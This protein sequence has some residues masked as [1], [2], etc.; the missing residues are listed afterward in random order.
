MPVA[1]QEDFFMMTLTA[2]VIFCMGAEN[3]PARHISPEVGLARPGGHRYSRLS[4][5]FPELS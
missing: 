3:D 5:H 4:H 2:E 1:G